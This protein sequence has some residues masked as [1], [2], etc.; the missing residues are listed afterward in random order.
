MDK[1]SSI[2]MILTASVLVSLCGCSGDKQEIIQA[3]DEYASAVTKFD[4]KDIASLMED[5]D[6]AECELEA[7]KERYE[8]NEVYEDIFDAVM[9]SMTY[10]IDKGSVKDG[11]VK[12]TFKFVDYE[13]IYEDVYDD[14]GNIEDY[15]EALENDDGETTTKITQTIDLINYKNEWLV[16]DKDYE[17]LLEIYGFIDEISGYGW[18]NFDVLTID[19]FKDILTDNLEIDS[20]E[21]AEYEYTWGDMA[22]K[23]MG[24]VYFLINEYNDTQ[25]DQSAQKTFEGFYEILAEDGYPEDSGL[26]TYYYDGN[27]GYILFNGDFYMEEYELYYYGG[28]Y[29]KDN[30]V[31]IAVANTPYGF[32]DSFYNYKMVNSFLEESGLPKPF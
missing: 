12:V 14:G 18:C 16:K 2:A 21:I 22:E 15:V 32:D 27:E 26:Y 29:V 20:S 28:I 11:S 19:E 17:N 6:E 30:V 3:A 9:S 10:E 13:Q 31:V 7:L 24:D 25:D 23:N 4:C 5:E 1:K 8:S